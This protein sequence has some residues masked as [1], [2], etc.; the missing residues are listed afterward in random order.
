MNLRSVSGLAVA[1]VLWAAPPSIGADVRVRVA[2]LTSSEIA[3][4]TLVF[5]PHTD[6]PRVMMAQRIE[7]EAGQQDF[8]ISVDQASVET[9]RGA[10][11]AT[12]RLR[13]G[14]QIQHAAVI[15]TGQTFIIDT[16]SGSRVEPDW[17]KPA[18][19]SDEPQGD[20]VLRNWSFSVGVGVETLAIDAEPE[21]VAAIDPNASP[22]GGPSA[23]SALTLDLD[24]TMRTHTIG[25][26]YVAESG[27]F[28]LSTRY[29]Y[30]ASD[31]QSAFEFRL[32]DNDDALGFSR[33]G[34]ADGQ[35]AQVSSPAFDRATASARTELTVHRVTTRATAH[36]VRRE[37]TEHGDLTPIVEVEYESVAIDAQASAKLTGGDD[38]AEQDLTIS[39]STRTVSVGAGIEVNRR[40]GYKQEHAIAVSLIVSADVV[41]YDVEAR[42]AIVSQ[43]LGVAEQADFRAKRTQ[44]SPGAKLE[45]MASFLRIGPARLTGRAGVLF[46]KRYG[47]SQ[48][49]DT[50]TERPARVVGDGTINPFAS[51]TA[52]VAF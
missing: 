25:A 3:E 20:I 51:I 46:R 9:F 26:E 52:S 2:G 38:D 35:T 31:G 21:L 23:L 45:G 12:V 10:A 30:A 32:T 42:Q 48:E 24:D 40:F 37:W 15:Y 43:S 14:G 19:L 29:Q 11:L 13:N 5:D 49:Q 41:T 22:D 33:F 6:R 18:R 28:T 47:F 34:G 50:F 17:R 27:A 4:I 16:D 44:V 39:Q 8:M 7:D 36:A 1:V